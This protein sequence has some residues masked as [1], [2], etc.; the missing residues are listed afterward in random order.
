MSSRLLLARRRDLLRLPSVAAAFVPSDLPGLQGWYKADSLALA[1]GAAVTTWPDSGPNGND[2][3]APGTA[4]VYAASVA[5]HGNAPGVQFTTP[6]YLQSTAFS[7]FTNAMEWF[8]VATVNSNA[9]TYHSL[10]ELGNGANF[11]GVQC[12]HQGD[13]SWRVKTVGGGVHDTATYIPIGGI[14][15]I[16]GGSYESGP[17]VTARWARHPVNITVATGNFEVSLTNLTLG[18]TNGA[19]GEMNGY[20]SEYLVYNRALTAAERTQVVEYLAGRYGLWK[21]VYNAASPLVTPTSDGSG[22]TVHPDVV[23]FGP[24]STWAGYRHWMVTTPFPGG[25]ASLENPEIL[26]STDGLAWVVPPGVTNPIDPDPDPAGLLH[27]DDPELFYDNGTMYAYYCS[28]DDGDNDKFL[29]RSSTDGFQ[30][31]SAETVLVDSTGQGKGFVSPAVSFDGTD[32]VCW[33]VQHRVAGANVLARMTASSPMG[34]WS[35]PTACTITGMDGFEP[36][37]LDVVAVGS[38]LYMLLTDQATGVWAD[39][40]M[41]LATSTDGGLTWTATRRYLFPVPLGEQNSKVYRATGVL[42]EDGKRFRVWYSA[43]GSTILGGWRTYYTEMPLS[44]AT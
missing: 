37:H 16:Y 36:W 4:P 10:F 30:T 17:G 39:H 23:D 26:A 34:P 5:T 24:G 27:N 43:E 13:A 7:G 15:V 25:D 40:H 3:T 19:G 33:Y 1:D 28:G 20:I 21:G 44:L 35:A 22:N 8:A 6:S 41:R 29:V 32:Y 14:D 9:N 38:T 11:S 2:L 12:W 42:S 31:V 18:R